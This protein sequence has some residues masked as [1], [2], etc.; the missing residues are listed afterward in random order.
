MLVLIIVYFILVCYGVT[1]IVVQSKLFKPFRELI[2]KRSEFFGSLVS[3]MMCFGFWVGLFTTIITGFSPSMMFY[4]GL[5]EHQ[6]GFELNIIFYIFDAAFLSSV[7][8]NINLVELYI[9]SKLPDE[10]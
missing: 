10:Q 1:S 4:K 7:I 6:H 9:E 3:C 8:Y 5:M 2:K